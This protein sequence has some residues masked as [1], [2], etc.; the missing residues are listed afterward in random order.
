MPGRQSMEKL[1][2]LLETFRFVAFSLRLRLRR[3][4]GIN[5]LRQGPARQVRPRVPAGP[6]VTSPRMKL[7]PKRRPCVGDSKDLISNDFL[8]AKD[9]KKK[10]KVV[11]NEDHK[12][13][14]CA[15]I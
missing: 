14:A 7:I 3:R 15:W 1:G 9:T 6:G 2:I 5:P 12:G 8:N 10:I 11:K 13:E 4:Y